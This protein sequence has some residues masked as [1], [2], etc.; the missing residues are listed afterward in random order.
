M[1][2]TPDPEAP[3]LSVDASGPVLRLRLE[4]PDQRN[5]LTR[6]ML[7]RLVHHVE[8][9]VDR[10]ELRAILLAG[11]G[12]DF[13]AG[14]D[15]RDANA[16]Q[17]TRPRVGDI[18]RRLPRQAHRLVLALLDVQL[19]VVAMVRGVASGLGA[20]LAFAA[21]LIVASETV[22][23]VEPFVARGFTPDSGG[24]FLLPRLVGLARARQV[25][26]LG[27]E[28]DAGT[29]SRWELVHEVV[30][31]DQLEPR[32]EALLGDLATRATL[33]LGLAKWLMNRA[34]DASATEALARE[35]QALELS[36]RSADFKEGLA[37]FA[38][39]RAPRYRGR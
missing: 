9:A 16:P 21:D 34:F 20:H 30:R 24:S 1:P 10:P 11:A 36:T 17:Q 38:E 5:A 29:A 19:P 33:A 27:R 25:L 6:P 18:Q 35:A 26:L 3:G 37:A 28:I 32:T 15:L 31:D 8:G 23:F 2:Y 7:D 13:C 4:R 12:A 14:A 39:K 22:R